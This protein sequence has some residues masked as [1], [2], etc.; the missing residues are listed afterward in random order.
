MRLTVEFNEGLVGE[1]F[2]KILELPDVV[3][4]GENPQEVLAKA[5]ALALHEVAG[6]VERGE[7]APEPYIA[8]NQCFQDPEENPK[9]RKSDRIPH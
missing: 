1:W 4:Y 7:I 9:R 3:T 2:A 8:F 5:Q 6:R